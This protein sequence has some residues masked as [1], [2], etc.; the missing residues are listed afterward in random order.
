MMCSSKKKAPITTIAASFSP[1]I[2]LAQAS[3]GTRLF[4][5]P[6]NYHRRAADLHMPNS[7][8][9]FRF[10]EPQTASSYRANLSDL[11]GSGSQTK[12]LKGAKSS[13]NSITF[14]LDLARRKT[15]QTH[16]GWAIRVHP[17]SGYTLQ[18]SHH[19]YILGCFASTAS[20]AKFA[21]YLPAAAD[22]DFGSIQLEGVA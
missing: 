9:P 2:D 8:G 16:N 12:I 3:Q 22:C 17:F 13:H 21:A 19:Q 20:A 7:N 4:R 15:P 18:N 6:G 1:L 11:N 5:S 14:Q 10:L